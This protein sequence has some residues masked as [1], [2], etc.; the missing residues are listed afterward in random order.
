LEAP[1]RHSY[2]ALAP[3]RVHGHRGS[4]GHG[5]RCCQVECAHWWL[6]AFRDG[7]GGIIRRLAALHPLAAL[8]YLFWR[9]PA[10]VPAVAAD[11]AADRPLE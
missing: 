4:F 11:L 9:V 6:L 10:D 2:E 8:A 5:V 3:D 7:Y 1:P